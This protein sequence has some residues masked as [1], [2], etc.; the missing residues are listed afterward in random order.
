MIIAIENGRFGNQLFQLNFCLKTAKK[1]ERIVLLG[2]DDLTKIIKK[3]NLIF[4]LRKNKLIL[5][6][7]K[8]QNQILK[9]L[10]KTKVINIIEENNHQKIIKT[11]GFFISLTLIN[12][13]FE[14][15]KF[16]KKD[17]KSYIKKNYL[18]DNAKDFIKTL[19]NKSYSK[20]FFIH[21]RLTDAVTGLDKNFP[22]VLP[23][24]WFF[25]CK[26][27]LLNKFKKCRFIYLSDDLN[28]LKEN[29]KN[30]IYIRNKNPFFSFFV[31]K[32]CDGGILSPSTF[33]WWAAY[34]SGGRNFYAPK[35]WHG[36]KKKKTY[37]KYIHS[38]FIK[39]MPV[40]KKE[41][42]SPLR[43]ERKF[44]TINL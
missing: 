37:P 15:E 35:Y 9:I 19:K 12:G 23:L 28:F 3:N 38:S 27:I 36:H 1:N 18:E 14:R 8:Y 13:Y 39:Y 41:Y 44:Y 6:F 40:L 29:F 5:F 16:I 22:S 31:M 17:F 11:K 25:K 21:I 42:L 4:F 26:N 7:L 33:S 30:N 10:K 20:I 32:H 24:A 34:L 43:N 2:F